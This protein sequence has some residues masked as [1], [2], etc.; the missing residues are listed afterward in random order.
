MIIYREKKT[1]WKIYLNV[2]LNI[3]AHIQY[4]VI[5][6]FVRCKALCT[7]TGWREIMKGKHLNGKW[8]AE[9]QGKDMTE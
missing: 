9:F 7:G 2:A 3:R 4:F 1:L 8:G 6:Q 5:L